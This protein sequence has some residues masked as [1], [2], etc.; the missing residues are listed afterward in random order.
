MTISGWT[1]SIY[2]Q[3]GNGTFNA[4]NDY[5]E[6]HGSA[7]WSTIYV[8]YTKD[9]VCCNS[10]TVN[11]SCTN[12]YA[13]T[14]ETRI[15]NAGDSWTNA[16][17]SSSYTKTFSTPY[18]GTIT[19]DVNV[20]VPTGLDVYDYGTIDISGIT[21]VDSPAAPTTVFSGSPT[22]GNAPLNVSFTNSSTGCPIPAYSW[23]FG[24][25]ESST[26]TSPS[27][28]YTDGGLYSVSLDA[29]NVVGSDTETKTDYI[30]VYQAPTS[31]S[32]SGVERTA[33]DV[34][35]DYEATPIAGYYSTIE[36]LWT[37]TGS[38]VVSED[39]TLTGST[40]QT[41][42]IT[43]NT[44]KTYTVTCT[45]TAKDSGGTQIGATVDNSKEVEVVSVQP[46]TSNAMRSDYCIVVN[47]TPYNNRR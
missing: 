40:L 4:T 12:D 8:K 23:D 10:Y 46:L 42:N 22:T 34:S 17:G 13:G 29:T 45:V 3:E 37:V 27:H 36:Y 7:S 33:A 15:R 14:I 1:A 2:S 32:I 26:D 31:L 19:I 38:G 30:T 21:I 18:T 6:A 25:G 9:V 41:C 16:Y 11:Y 44:I 47:Y 43:F 35:L 5:L 24:D 28:S 20:Y 39:Y